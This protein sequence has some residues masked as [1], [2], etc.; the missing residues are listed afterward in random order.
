[1]VEHRVALIDQPLLLAVGVDPL[2][3]AGGAPPIA[4][5]EMAELADARRNAGGTALGEEKGNLLCVRHRGH[6]GRRAAAHSAVRMPLAPS[7][8]T[9]SAAHAAAFSGL[10]QS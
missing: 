7:S 3:R 8:R 2:G 10:P 1:M 6:S 9:S 4:G 5:A